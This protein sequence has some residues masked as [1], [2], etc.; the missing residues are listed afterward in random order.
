MTGIR[1]V[2]GRLGLGRI[3][4]KADEIMQGRH[5][6]EPG[7]G[8]EGQLPMSFCVTWGP[9]DLAGFLDP[10]GPDFLLNNLEGRVTIGGLCEDVPCSGKLALRYFGENELEYTFDFQVSG[11]AY[12]FNGKKVNIRP[13]NLPVSHTTC[14][15]ILREAETGKL[16]SRS[17][18]HF[19]LNTIPGFLSSFRLARAS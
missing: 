6:F 17:V 15:G 2:L 7:M 4:F 12:I 1:N 18:T 5:R 3:R 13:W 14:F 9:A 19:R 16:V 11:R 10:G 8:P